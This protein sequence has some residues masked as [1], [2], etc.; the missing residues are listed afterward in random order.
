MVIVVFVVGFSLF[1]LVQNLG[2]DEQFILF[3]CLNSFLTADSQVQ[4]K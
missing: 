3:H 4:K 1:F 2:D